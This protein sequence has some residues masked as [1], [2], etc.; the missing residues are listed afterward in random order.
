MPRIKEKTETIRTQDQEEITP[1]KTISLGETKIKETKTP[2]GGEITIN[3]DKGRTITL[4]STSLV[5]YVV[6]MD[7]ILTIAPKLL[8]SNK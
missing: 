2:K 3:H 4:E 6:S 7:I 5:L 1:N 8:I